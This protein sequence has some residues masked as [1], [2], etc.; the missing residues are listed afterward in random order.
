LA[1]A[2]SFWR[3]QLQ[4][5]ILAQK[6]HFGYSLQRDP[7]SKE[8]QAQLKLPESQSALPLSRDL[9]I[10]PRSSELATRQLSN[11]TDGHYTLLY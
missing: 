2:V 4:C 10:R 3:S 11:G 5:F 8:I 7:I 6:L 9:R 1:L